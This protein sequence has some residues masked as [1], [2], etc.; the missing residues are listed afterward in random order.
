MGKKIAFPFVKGDLQEYTW[1][2]LTDEETE[3]VYCGSKVT[4]G[5]IEWMPNREVAL[6]LYYD[7]YGRGRSAVT[8]Y[9]TDEQG[10]RY[11]MFIKDFDDMIMR[12]DTIKP[13]KGI[14]T[15]VKRGK[16]YGIKLVR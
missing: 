8:F 6:A 4:Q 11:P 12:I 15:Y 9:W 5:D 16:N 10:H 14:F 1:R 2:N 13:A 7:G 3:M